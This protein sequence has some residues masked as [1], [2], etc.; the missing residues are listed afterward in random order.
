M[1]TFITRIELNAATQKDYQILEEEMKK[2]SFKD[3]KKGNSR[4]QPVMPP[5]LEFNCNGNSLLEVT[6]A[7]VKAVR[8]TGRNYS[9]TVMKERKLNIH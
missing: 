4:K 6:G 5:S 9:F 1:P 7:A 8:R 3:V 2:A